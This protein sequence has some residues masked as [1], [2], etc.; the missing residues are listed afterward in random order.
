MDAFDGI[1]NQ[2]S[3]G[4]WTYTWEYGRQLVSMSDGTTTWTYTYDADG[5]R[6]GRAKGT[7]AYPYV[8]KGRSAPRMTKTNDALARFLFQWY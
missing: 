5:M 2:L 1:G 8:Y 7:N 6:I 3:D 4:I